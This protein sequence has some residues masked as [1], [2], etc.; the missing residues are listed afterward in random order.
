MKHLKKFAA[1]TGVAC[2]L[3]SCGTSKITYLETYSPEES[4]LNL[5]KV[6]DEANNTVLAGGSFNPAYTDFSKS[7]YG[8]STN[9]GWY[10]HNLLSISPDGSKL[11]YC[12]RMNGQD[13]IMVRNAA[14]LGTS[15]QRTFRNVHSFSWGS[16]NKLYFSDMNGNNAYI[17]RV[18]AESG[19]LMDQ[20]TNGMV[21]DYN[22]V[23]SADGKSIF[24]TRV[25]P[26]G[27]SIWSLNTTNGTLTSCSRGYSPCI[28]K[29]EPNAF[30]C[31][32]NTATKES[33]IWYVDF[34]N[35]KESVVLSFKGMGFTNPQLS[36]DG[37]WLLCV[38]SS[39]SSITKK[40]NLDIYVV[41]TD[42]TR[43]TQL[44][45]HPSN[46]TSPVWSADGRS[47]YFISSRAN[48]TE[49]YNVWRMNFNLE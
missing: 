14:S 3:V 49:A 23:L 18:N 42:G 39:V 25:T 38:G 19:S 5:I 48:K 41:R 12:T 9:L 32:R 30:Y 28:I 29:N 36:P 46:D 20:L 37:K 31:V 1:A 35:G 8:A 47:I 21:N 22:P 6:T 13:N 44:T 17:C 33:E 24:F 7:M 16:D 26:T 2:L 11:A 10:T 43:L 34:V 4:S 27:P 45:Y 15:T 40:S